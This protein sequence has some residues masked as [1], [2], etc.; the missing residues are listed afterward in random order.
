MRDTDR[1]ILSACSA[2]EIAETT[3]RR[4][5]DLVPARRSSVL[6]CAAADVVA[7]VLVVQSEMPTSLVVGVQVPAG[8]IWCPT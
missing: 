3:L 7:T 1:D 8:R 5:A 4:M 2:V 6:L